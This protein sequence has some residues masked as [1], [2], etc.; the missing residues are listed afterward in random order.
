MKKLY[1]IAPTAALIVFIGLYLRFCHS[2]S[3]REAQR[4]EAVQVERK[5]QAAAEIEARRQA[6][7]EAVRL[8]SD[9]QK[10]RDARD[11]LE[12]AQVATRQAALAARDRALLEKQTLSRQL[13]DLRQELAAENATLA[14]LSVQRSTQLAEQAFLKTICVQAEA[15]VQAIAAVIAKLPPAEAAVTVGLPDPARK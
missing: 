5:T 8:Q 7:V 10:E 15:N 2:Q 11:A 3:V 4:M 1:L 13:D 6:V 14:Q 9:R 12:R